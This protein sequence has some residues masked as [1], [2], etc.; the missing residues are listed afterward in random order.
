M[1]GIAFGD[2]LNGALLMRIH[3]SADEEKDE[4]WAKAKRAK[5]PEREWRREMELDETVHDGEPVFADYIDKFHCPWDRT[6]LPLVKG[7]TYIGGWDCGQTLIPAFVLLQITPRPWQVQAILEVVSPGAEPMETFAPRVM[8]A[9]IKRL[10]GRWDEVEHWADQTVTTPSGANGETAQQNAK[11][12]GFRLR[13]ASNEWS[14]RY[15]GV[16]WMLAD[17]LDAGEPRYIVDGFHCPV[18]R[19]GFQGAYKLDV[20]QQG[21]AVGPGRVLANKPLKDSF[22]HVHDGNQYACARAKKLIQTLRSK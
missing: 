11:K 3:Y 20:T 4:V 19:S 12:K 16:T 18:L 8:M 14:G 9:L 2:C 5:T 7:A 15:G 21:D 13:P 17:R 22:S 10:P 1:K 6:P